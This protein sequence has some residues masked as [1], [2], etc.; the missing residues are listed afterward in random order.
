MAQHGWRVI[1]KVEGKSRKN[2]F[3]VIVN[4]YVNAFCGVYQ[5]ISM[6]G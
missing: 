3:H 4:G 5:W 1:F 2:F 6:S